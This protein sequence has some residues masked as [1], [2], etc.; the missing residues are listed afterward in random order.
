VAVIVQAEHYEAVENIEAIVKV[1]GIDAVLVGPYDLSASLGRPGDLAHP[2]VTSAIDH[3]TQ[4]CLG[5]GVPLGIFRLTADALKPY[6][7]RG[8][9][10][11][12]AGVDT[13]F[14]SQAAGSL[15]AQI[16]GE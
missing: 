15:L 16:N 3:V 1:E 9:T 7:E 10:L 2:E 6:I 5:A 14:L 11:L 13:L 4:T 12:V 8:Y